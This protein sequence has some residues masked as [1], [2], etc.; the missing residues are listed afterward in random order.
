MKHETVKLKEE[1]KFRRYIRRTFRNKLCAMGLL[2]IGIFSAILS[3]DITFLIF[4]LMAGVPLFFAR[5]D[6]MEL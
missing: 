2:M 4:T 1:T 3:K 5:K 6:M